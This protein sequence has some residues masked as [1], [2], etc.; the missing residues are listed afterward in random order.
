[1]FFTEGVLFLL[2]P[3]AIQEKHWLS[4]RH[5][6]GWQPKVFLPCVCVRIN[7]LTNIHRYL[8][9]KSRPVIHFKFCQANL[10]C[11]HAVHM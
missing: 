2:Q 1:M 6:S 10:W 8:C 4:I 5:W 7:K 3:G 11:F 9:Q